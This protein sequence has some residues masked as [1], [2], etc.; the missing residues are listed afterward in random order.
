MISREQWGAT[1]GRGYETSGAK[2]TLVIHHDGHNRSKENMTIEEES[3][4]MRLFERFHV[5]RLTQTSPRIAYSFVVMQSGRVYEGCGWNRVGAHTKD[6]NSSSYGVCLPIHG[7]QTIPT[8]KAREAILNLRI[9]GVTQGYLTDNHR[10]AGHQ[11]Y[12]KPGCPGNLVYEA[13]VI[14]ARG[15]LVGPRLADYIHAMPTLRFGKGGKL[16]SIRERETVRYLQQLLISGGFLTDRLRNGQ[17]SA[18]G[19][20]GPATREAVIRFQQA[21]GLKADGLVGLKTWG[22]LD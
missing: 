10:V 13:I 15:S 12:N 3:E 1:H 14:L 11:D 22:K 20:F 19:Y 6:L 7:G 16:A 17:T 8:K 21:V 4:I 9:E 5:S 18:T 2:T